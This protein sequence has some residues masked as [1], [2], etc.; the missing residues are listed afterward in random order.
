MKPIAFD[1]VCYRIDGRPVYLHSGEF[2]YFRVP[3]ADW[4]RRMELFKEAGGNCI[5]TY[6][7]WLIHEPAEGNI[8]FGGED[9]C[10]DLVG[11]LQTA[12]D[13]GLYVIARP[14]PYQY[15]ELLYDGLPGWLCENYPELRAHNIQRQPFRTSSASYLHPLFLDKVRTWFS[16]VCP[17]IA[18]YTVSKGG[19][20]AFVQLDNELTGIHRW[21]GSLDYNAETMGFGRSDG[22]YPRFLRRRYSDISAL[23]RL[24]KTSYCAFEEVRP[25]ALYEAGKQ[26]E[27]RCL[28]DYLD[29]YL[30]TVAEYMQ[31]LAR[32]AREHGIDTPLIHN[33]A[34]PMDNAFFYETVQAMGDSFLLGSDH[35]YNLSADW[36]QNNP[37]PQYAVNVF[38]SNEM[39]RLLGFP[40][41]VLELPGGS[42]VDWPPAT[43]EDLQTC[44]LT[45]VAL[46]MKGSN[47]YILTGGPNV[48]GT[49][50]T[51][52][53]YDYG[54]AI[55][56]YGE[57]RPLYHVQKEFGRFMA[58]RPWLVE[59][60][61][62][63]ACRLALDMEYPR[64][65][66]YWKRRGELPFSAGEAWNLIRKGFL[67]TAFCASLSP[68]LVNLGT[69]DWLGDSGTPVVIVAASSM[70]AAKQERIVRFL[71]EGGRVLIAPVLPVVDERLEPCTIL[72]DFLGSPAIQACERP[73]TR[74]TVA[75]VANIYNNGEVFFCD[76]LPPGA[77][78][79]GHDELTGRPVAW[80]R[81]FEGGGQVI[82]LGFRWLHAMREHER[83]LVALLKKLGISLRVICTNP[84]V[85]TALRT[86]GD[87][88]ML[89]IMNLL[90]SSMEGEISCHP[91]WSEEWIHTGR[92]KLAPM[93]VKMVEI[94]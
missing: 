3:R 47:Y 50:A 85:W 48:L 31:I 86:A 8:I 79:L 23:N 14:G 66:E 30:E 74:L 32:M 1:K 7:P 39:L 4:R 5:A 12:R 78:L 63:S 19:P 69:D 52:D 9:G 67:P 6:I 87:R 34:N 13:V 56:A 92:H 25:L 91:R 20:V 17:L 59:A 41:T 93:T 45:N 72:A 51:C 53:I 11:F 88:S 81:T 75:D 73:Y 24:Y 36:P 33:S 49:G 57:V 90:S 15:S 68:T 35:Y 40:P 18:G 94:P 60:E 61:A 26:T 46:G 37:T 80:Q 77:V 65:A 22:R 71:K 29:F 44:Y 28:K 82:F 54:A 10:R 70:A 43:P 76:N 27:I 64:A 16:H 58:A 21:F 89:F 55:G 84:N 83:M 2:H 62:E 42:A 38:C